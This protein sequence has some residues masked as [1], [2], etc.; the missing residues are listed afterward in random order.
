M[1][2]QT[3]ELE[4]NTVESRASGVSW[5]AIAGGSAATSA[6]TLVLLAFGAGMGFSA[7]SPWNS[8]PSSTTFAIVAGVYLLVVAVLASSVGGYIAGRLRTKW[9]GLHT[10]EVFFRDTAHGFLSWAF[11][12]VISAALL[13]SAATS[14]AGGAAMGGAQAVG[15]AERE[16]S[17]SN[18][19]SYFV[20]SLLRSS[21]QAAGSDNAAWRGEAARIFTTGLYGDMAPADRAYLA[22]L[23]SARTGISQADAEKRITEV[24]DQAKV[25][26]DKARKAA[27]ALSLWLAA[28]MLLGAFAASL[29]ATE[30]GELRDRDQ[31]VA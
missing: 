15:G 8:G 3:V 18:S 5:G 10:H 25:A 11:A 19:T 16:M 12:S 6:L 28:S 9:V 17:N 1:S 31:S 7:V 23:I 2:L 26:T 27:A 24:T 22:Q 13:A 30:G 4:T 21:T 29:A 14:I 20:D